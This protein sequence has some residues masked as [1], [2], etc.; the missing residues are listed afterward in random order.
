[1]PYRLTLLE[2]LPAQAP[3]ALQV[4]YTYGDGTPTTTWDVQAVG[5]ET[6]VAVINVNC[7]H[8][9]LTPQP[10]S[11]RTLLAHY[12]AAPNLR[13]ISI[14]SVQPPQELGNEEVMATPTPYEID[15]SMNGQTVNALQ[16]PPNPYFLYG[17]K[18]VKASGNGAPLVWFKTSDYG[19]ATAL[20]WTEQYQA[21]TSL[22]Q[23]VPGGKITAT[24]AY[25]IGLDNT[26]DVASPDGTGSVDTLQGA[27]SAISIA[28]Q[29]ST[30]FTT[31]ISQVQPDGTVTPMCAFPLYGNMLD[32]I[33]PIEL[34]LL[35][36]STEAYNT[37][38]VVEQSYSAGVLVDLTAEQT[39]SLNFDINAGWSW[40]GGPW[41]QI[42]AP[43]ENL[44]PLLIQSS[45]SL[46]RSLLAQPA[47]G[48]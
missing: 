28:N 11:T 32:A 45:A 38:T 41:A 21:Y 48:A 1:M 33:A 47:M 23:I 31:G 16:A 6:N 25:D 42:V 9:L 13:R 39:R 14:S 46:S 19:L 35:M 18:A 5:A 24:N 26:L 20:S 15:I 43:N 7:A 8:N 12:P 29:T 22:D 34:V 40:G 3:S 44:V 10:V 37:G 2:T 17:F 4:E 27:P 30:Q 36:F